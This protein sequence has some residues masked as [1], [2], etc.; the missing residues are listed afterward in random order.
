MANFRYHELAELFTGKVHMPSGAAGAAPT[1]AA[2]AGA[3]SAHRKAMT[4]RRF[5]TSAEAIRFAIEE[6]PAEG[7]AATVL[8]MDG[9][10]FD[11]EAIRGLY[12]APEYPLRRRPRP[13]NAV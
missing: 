5:A 10:R 13:R 1:N 7:L 4:Y 8:E 12:D 3:R 9:D 11:S 6:L 2:R